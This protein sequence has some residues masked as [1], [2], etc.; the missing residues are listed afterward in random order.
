M[1]ILAQNKKIRHEY[2]IEEELEVGIVLTGDEVLS[3]R[4]G[5]CNLKDSYVSLKTGE[6]YLLGCHISAYKNAWLKPDEKRDKKLL[7]HKRE[8]NKLIGISAEKGVTL[9]VDK[10]Y[11]ADNGRIKCN[12]CVA[13]GKH[14]YDKRRDIA[15]KDAKRKMDRA[16]KEFNNK[17]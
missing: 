5:K 4:Q 17:V 13:K 9:V 2:F 12:L 6:A 7:M 1:K 11:V 15:N 3:I 10:V 8:L 16:L 14:N